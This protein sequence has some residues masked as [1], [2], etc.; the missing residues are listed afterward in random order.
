MYDCLLHGR[1][2]SQAVV[3]MMAARMS[4]LMLHEACVAHHRSSVADAAAQDGGPQLALRFVAALLCPL[5]CS[6]LPP[7]VLEVLLSHPSCDVR[8]RTVDG[9]TALHVAAACG[10]APLVARLLRHS[11]VEAEVA[12]NE[13]HAPLHHA[14]SRGHVGVVE[15]LWPRCTR[16]EAA[17][18][19]GKTPL[20]LA[21]EAGHT[22]VVARLVIAGCC[23]TQKDNGGRTPGHLAAMGGHRPAME[24]LLLAGLEVDQAVGVVS[25]LRV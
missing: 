20:H 5:H 16:M 19:A 2:P 1:K 10:H 7:Q 8:A 21:A 12:D 6:A 9:L 18:C 25:G 15:V 14:A 23:V 4:T 13:G 24:K 11:G 17:S 22:E 3:S